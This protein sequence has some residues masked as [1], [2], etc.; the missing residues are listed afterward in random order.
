MAIGTRQSAIARAASVALLLAN[1]SLAAF[2][3]TTR[4]RLE[5]KVAFQNGALAVNGKAVRWSD[6][7][8][9]VVG[10]GGRRVTAPHAVRL[11]NGE[12]WPVD[13]VGMTS[14]EAEVRSPLFGRRQIERKLLAELLFAPL[15][16]PKRNLAPSTLYRDTGEPIPGSIVWIDETK[17][18]LDGPLGVMTVAR[19]GTTRYLFEA[20]AKEKPTPPRDETDLHLVDG[21]V[22]RGRVA[23]HPSR[24]VVRHAVLG[25]VEVPTVA[26]RALMRRPTTALYLAEQPF[27]AVDTKPL[28]A[29]AAKPE[30][31]LPPEAA[32]QGDARFLTGIRLWPTTTVRFRLARREGRRPVLR[33]WLGLTAESRGDARVRIVAGREL[34]NETLA[35]GGKWKPLSVELPAGGELAIEV[36]FGARLRFPCCVVF[37][38]PHVLLGP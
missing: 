29:H 34:L 11:T 35:P 8:F 9:A 30:R 18:A 1:A 3:Q 13:L 10:D 38:D 27:A 26:L 36:T 28:V 7:L 17:I 6:V 25:S 16:P 14:R 32:R 4:G 24:L 20:G 33:G 15:L 5:G 23:L 12:R 2:V 22:L 31:L 37:G 19:E 21:T